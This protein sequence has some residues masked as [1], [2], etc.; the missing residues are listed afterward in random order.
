[1][2]TR[3]IARGAS[4]LLVTS[5]VCMALVPWAV[6]E[7]YSVVEH[8]LSE[9]AGQGVEGGWLARTGVIL[10]A[11]AAFLLAATPALRW[12]PWSRL[13]H[14]LFA[15]FTVFIAIFEDVPFVGGDFDQVE[16]WIHSVVTVA[17]GTAFVVGVWLVTVEG[18]HLGRSPSPFDRVALLAPLVLPVVMLRVDGI[19]GLAQRLMLAAGIW[20]YWRE[21]RSVATGRSRNRTRDPRGPVTV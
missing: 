4:H 21:A 5:V 7:S 17:A 14:R 13:A 3:Q 8:T 12:G 11:F 18:R 20:W 9:A 16:G 6:S 10:S 2:D 15:V 1:L 19:D